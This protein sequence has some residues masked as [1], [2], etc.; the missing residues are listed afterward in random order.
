MVERVLLASPRGYCAGVERAID[1][2]RQA[3]CRF[4][5]PVYVRKQIVH[6]QH[7]LREL[8]ADGAVFVDSE[9]EVPHGSMLVFSAHGVSPAVHAGAA[10]R[11]LNVIDSTCPLVT[12]VHLE[13]RRFAR[14]GY[15]IVLI[16]HDGHEEV[17]GTLGEAPDATVLVQTAD[18]TKALTLDEAERVAYLTQTTLSVDETREIIDILRRRFPEIVGPRR[19][20]ICYATTN[21]QDAV[22]ALLAHVDVLLVVGSQNSSNSNRLVDVAASGGVPGYL[23]EDE[24][25]I[26]DEWLGQASS[27]GLTAG[28][29]APERIVQR[30]CQWFRA[31][32][33]SE[34]RELRTAVETVA[35]GLPLPLRDEAA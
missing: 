3:L 26:R 25:S 24:H 22:K 35:F 34:I 31:R 9:T 5:P 13:A 32:G 2:V 7:V 28:A 15:R 12:K 19:D 29:S 6:N 8:E 23:I 20:D 17:E 1:T 27:V 10:S 30:V 18:D 21:W 16:G 11:S 4:G 14:E 33:V